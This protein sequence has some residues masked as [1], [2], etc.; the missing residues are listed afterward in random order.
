MTIMDDLCCVGCVRVRSKRATVCCVLRCNPMHKSL[1]DGSRR[2]STAG[3]QPDHD[4]VTVE[5]KKGTL[6][7]MQRGSCFT[8]PPWRSPPRPVHLLLITLVDGLHHHHHRLGRPTYHVVHNPFLDEQR[9]GLCVFLRRGHNYRESEP[10][11]KQA[12]SLIRQSALDSLLIA[13]LIFMIL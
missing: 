13:F 5:S 10:Q 6:R 3:G 8:C 2:G 4:Y 12:F 7:A 9:R 1:L 11:G